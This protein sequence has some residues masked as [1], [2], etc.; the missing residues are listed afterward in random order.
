MT[1]M[2]SGAAVAFAQTESLSIVATD[3]SRYPQVELTVAAPPPLVEQRGEASY[4]VREGGQLR[5]VVVAAQPVD[6]LELALVVDTSG[7]MRGAPLAEA[8]AAAQSFLV[9]LPPSATVTVVAFGATP[10]ELSTRSTDRAE[11]LAAVEGLRAGGETALYDAL[12]LV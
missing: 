5:P 3:L 7:S 4:Q 9:Q 12:Q 10:V 11:Q 1:T 2:A 8:K 6:R